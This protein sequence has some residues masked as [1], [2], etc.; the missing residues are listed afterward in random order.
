MAVSLHSVIPEVRDH[1]MPINR[2]YPL[3]QLQN[4]VYEQFWT[5]KPN[6]MSVLMDFL[7][8]F[9]VIRAAC[10]EFL[11]HSSRRKIVFEYT[12]LSGVNDSLS[13]AD[14][15]VRWLAGMQALVNLIPFNTWPGTEVLTRWCQ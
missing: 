9:S 13:D 15:L 14:D 1:L 2:T 7:R 5:F 10:R 12:M 8:W 11:A 4:G 3:D 6:Y